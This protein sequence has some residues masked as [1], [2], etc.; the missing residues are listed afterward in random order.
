MDRG[1]VRTSDGLDI[2]RVQC[3]D[4]VPNDQSLVKHDHDERVEEIELHVAEQ[5][6]T[7]SGEEDSCACARERRGFAREL[8]V[9]VWSRARVE[10]EQRWRV[11]VV[12]VERDASGQ[13]RGRE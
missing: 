1:A 10:I 2:T 6:W 8:S 3:L 5:D 4:D 7:E 9:S 11:R 12:V 13:V